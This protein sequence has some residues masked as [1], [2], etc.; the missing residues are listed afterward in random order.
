MNG[1]TISLEYR[2]I[3]T[4]IMEI[5]KK[6]IPI[7]I[8]TSFDIPHLVLANRRNTKALGAT[9]LSKLGIMVAEAFKITSAPHPVIPT[10]Y[11]YGPQLVGDTQA[12]NTPQYITPLGRDW[13]TDNGDVMGSEKISIS[14][15]GHDRFTRDIPE[16]KYIAKISLPL[17]DMIRMSYDLL[18]D[19]DPPTGSIKVEGFEAFSEPII[20]TLCRNFIK[21]ER[22]GLIKESKKFGEIN[23]KGVVEISECSNELDGRKWPSRDCLKIGPSNNLLTYHAIYFLNRLGYKANRN[24]IA[25]LLASH[26]LYGKSRIEKLIN[27]TWKSRKR[28]HE[29][30]KLY[31]GGKIAGV[32]QK[33]IDAIQKIKNCEEEFKPLESDVLSNV[34]RSLRTLHEKERNV[35]KKESGHYIVLGNVV[36]TLEGC[37]ELPD[38]PIY[39]KTIST[40][41]EF[42]KWMLKAG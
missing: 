35:V 32:L 24:S 7:Q 31:D 38:R 26:Y 1:R 12:M 27:D 17:E 10:I 25:S 40:I 21:A 42:N 22:L 8:E 37:V 34:E 5:R 4:R 23:R 13:G 6:E 29:S 16:L 15:G 19:R 28:Y 41:R 11:L 20:N 18:F 30:R 36:E 2:N 33:E 9:Y 3:Y 39:A 14:P